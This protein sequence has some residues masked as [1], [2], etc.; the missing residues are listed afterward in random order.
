MGQPRF[1]KIVNGRPMIDIGGLRHPITIQ[2]REIKSPP[3][4]DTAGV[5]IASAD[6][7]R[8]LAAIEAIRGTDTIRNGQD[9]TQLI[10]AIGI[11]WQAGILANMLITTESGSVYQIQAVE[12]VLEMN[13]VL[14]L[15]CIAL[16]ASQ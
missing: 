1:L 5:A 4:Y 13:I 10:L 16:G 7:T 14:V 2:S 15:T 8:A 9:S 11:W 3:D 12:N 6:F